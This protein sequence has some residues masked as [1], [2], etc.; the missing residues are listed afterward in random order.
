MNRRSCCCRTLWLAP[1]LVALSGPAP[2]RADTPSSATSMEAGH[3][4]LRGVLMPTVDRQLSSRAAGVVE[5]FGAEEGQLIAIGDLLVQL[6]ADI[7]RAELAR[8]EAVL[9][10]TRAEYDY[11]GRK[12][13]RRAQLRREEIGSEKDFE[14]ASHA[15]R[16]A[17]AR[18]KQAEA[19]V[20]M[21]R[22]R[23]AERSIL[24]PISGILFR[25]SRSV[26]E[27]IERL[28]PVVRVVDASKLEF[29]VYAEADLLGRF[30]LHDVVTVVLQG[31]PGNGQQVPATVSSID[32]ILDA[33][34]GTF[35]IRFAM[36]PGE[37]VHPGIAVTV[38]ISTERD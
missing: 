24:S 21:A 1:L 5:K 32:P 36:Q 17:E 10:S 30:M 27:A 22:A 38:D 2:V 19:E 25:R 12:L 6:N 11:T 35:R 34:S 33:E 7:E 29:L 26:G 37:H 13:E 14:D 4:P 23:L 28:E 8:T 9:E 16:L 31:G 3:P 15:H 18:R 20:S